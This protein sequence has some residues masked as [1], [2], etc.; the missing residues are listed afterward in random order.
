MNQVLIV[1]DSALARTL[2]RRSIEACG[3]YDL[4]FNEASNGLMALDLLQSEE[5]DLV[6]SD[7]NMPEMDGEDLLKKIKNTPNLSHIGVVIISSKVNNALMD[8]LIDNQALAVL[9]K[10]LSIPRLHDVL[11]NA[12]NLQQG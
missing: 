9:S 6:F 10:P 11:Q 7:L 5:H 2:I 12:L 8:K 4:H 3:F 1:D